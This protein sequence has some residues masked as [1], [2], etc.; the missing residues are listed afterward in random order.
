MNPKIKEWLK[1]YIPAN[2]FCTICTLIVSYVIFYSTNNRVLTA[3]LSSIIGTICYYGFIL[4]RDVIYTKRKYIEDS[5]KYTFV[6]FIKN[7]NNIII[8]FGFSEIL[9]T[10]FVTPFFMYL[11][12]LIINDIVIGTLIAKYASDIVFYIPTIIA[13]EL[14]K[15]HLKK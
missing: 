9:D 6:S 1:R 14:R 10:F 5:K 3:F 2:L 8:E 12:P 13:Y 15:K 7:V 11:F 4:V